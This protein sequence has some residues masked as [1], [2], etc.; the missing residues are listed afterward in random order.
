MEIHW[1]DVIASIVLGIGA[2]LVYAGSG[3]AG[4]AALIMSVIWFFII[5]IGRHN[6]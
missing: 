3:S 2:S 5:T 1:G 6:L 4:G